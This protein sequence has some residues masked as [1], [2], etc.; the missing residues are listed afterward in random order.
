MLEYKAFQRIPST[1]RGHKLGDMEQLIEQAIRVSTN[2][3]NRQTRVQDTSLE[4]L[5]KKTFNPSF[6]SSL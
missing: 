4:I 1:K 2:V 3:K 5:E 6:C